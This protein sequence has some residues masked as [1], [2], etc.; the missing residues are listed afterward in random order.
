MAPAV[1]LRQPPGSPWCQPKVEHPKLAG[2]LS[3]GRREGTRGLWKGYRPD[4]WVWGPPWPGGAW[5]QPTMGPG[6]G[7]TVKGLGWTLC[8]G[9]LAASGTRVRSCVR[10]L[11]CR[12]P[13]GGL[14]LCK[15][16]IKPVG[17][18]AWAGMPDG[19]DAQTKGQPPAGRQSGP[20][21]LRRD[22]AG[23][24]CPSSIAGTLHLPHRCSAPWVG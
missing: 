8:S 3:L 12:R 24:V 5:G 15:H 23:T 21:V 4:I 22:S 16:H 7:G 10:Y 20:T 19:H 9:D 11:G 1:K 18:L 6:G 17:L 14:G 13:E 2:R